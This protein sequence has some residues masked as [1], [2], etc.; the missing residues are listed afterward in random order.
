MRDSHAPPPPQLTSWLL[1]LFVPTGRADSIVGDLLEEFTQRAAHSG[2]GV[3]RRWYRGQVLRSIVH[4]LVLQLRIAP[5]ATIGAVLGG[6]ALQ[7]YSVRAV[8]FTV[9]LLLAH[10]SVYR[11][12]GAKAFWLIYGVGVELILCSLASGWLSAAI[13]KGREMAV[14]VTLSL[15]R[16]T[17]L[18]PWLIFVF[19]RRPPNIPWLHSH[20]FYAQSMVFLLLPPIFLFVGAATCRKRRSSVCR[21]LAI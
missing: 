2:R 10:V 5:G 13:S 12:V 16:G 7:H 11:Y 18:V 9:G 15:V 3:A 1:D 8:D 17:A 14:G 4:L 19:W 20:A 6:L 21:R